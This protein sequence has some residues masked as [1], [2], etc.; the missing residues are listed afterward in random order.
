MHFYLESAFAVAYLFLWSVGLYVQLF[1]TL[2][3]KEAD[4]Y[5]LDTQIFFLIGMLCYTSYVIYFIL[6]VKC[7]FISLCDLVSSIQLLVLCIIILSLTLYYPRSTNRFHFSSYIIISIVFMMSSSFYGL[8]LKFNTISYNDFILFWGI[9]ASVLDGLESIYQIALN[10][11]RKSCDGLA[12]EMI[13]SEGLASLLML[14][15]QAVEAYSDKDVKLNV[16]KITIAITCL[17][18]IVI[19]LYQYY[20]L[21]N[22]KNKVSNNAK[23]VL[24]A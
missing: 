2:R 19:I 11:D 21:Y 14:M 6:Y 5:S 8:Q 9:S 18:S 22:V 7:D 23:E 16:P 1:E 17:T 10:Y 20:F 13:I 4:G 12:I 3:T 15:E 24:A